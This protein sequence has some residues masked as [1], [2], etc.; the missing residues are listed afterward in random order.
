M[1]PIAAALLSGL[2]EKGLGLLRDALVAKGKQK[3]EEIIG[4]KLP[5]SEGDLT[6]EVTA[7]LK[8]AMMTHEEKLLE[9]SLKKQELDLEGEKLSVDNTKD[10]RGMNARIQES[11]NSSNLA[12]NAAYYLDFA[13]IGATVGLAFLLFF[14]GVPENNKELAYTAF[15]SLMTLSGTIINFHR[16][17]SQSSKNKTELLNARTEKKDE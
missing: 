6:P 8:I 14:I 1:I 2:A 3:V 4:M 5:S 13:I 7:Q 17:S 9:L 16:G 10:A 11:A 15:G 12:K